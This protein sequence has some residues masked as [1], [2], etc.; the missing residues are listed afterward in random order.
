M[1]IL[2]EFVPQHREVGGAV[3]GR[4]NDLAVD[5]RGACADVP[6]LVGDL[7]EAFGPV[8]ATAGEDLDRAVHKMDLDAIPIEFDLMYPAVAAG[9]LLD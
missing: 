2:V 8:V 7:L 4:D 6:G 5:D 1:T 9:H 3:G